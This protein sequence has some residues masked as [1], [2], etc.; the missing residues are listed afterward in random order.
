[1]VNLFIGKYH[2][3]GGFTTISIVNT[4][5]QDGNLFIKAVKIFIFLF[6]GRILFGFDLSGACMIKNITDW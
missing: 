6:P 1:M 4:H 5:W 2:R 3:D